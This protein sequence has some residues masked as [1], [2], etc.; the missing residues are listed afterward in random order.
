MKSSFRVPLMCLAAL[1][2]GCA[3]PPEPA[4]EAPPVD[5]V[6]E[7]GAVKVV[8]DQLAQVWVDEDLDLLSRIFAHDPDMVLFGTD[9]AEVFV[10]F[11]PLRASLEAQFTAFDSGIATRDQVIRV[12]AGG[13]VAWFSQL[14]DLE[15][16]TPGESAIVN[17]M[18]CTG[19]L[20]KRNGAWVFVQFHGSIPVAGQVVAY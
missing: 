12:H 3:E 4:D 17:G 2:A 13:E 8:V 7:K 20:E 5:L 6:A 11:E 14:W 19:V 18:R 9:S 15:V 10:G 1:L 16:R